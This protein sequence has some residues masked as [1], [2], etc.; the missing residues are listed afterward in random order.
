LTGST[1]SAPPAKC[2][3]KRIDTHLGGFK[4]EER[5]N[6]LIFYLDWTLICTG[7]SGGCSG[8]VEYEKPAHEPGGRLTQPHFKKGQQRF[9]VHCAGNCQNTPTS[10]EV[11]FVLLWDKRARANK[12]YVLRT[13]AECPALGVHL[14][15][16]FSL[17]FNSNGELDR[18][19][20][21]LGKT[22]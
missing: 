16:N 13:T 2:H 17:H 12:T 22:A 10:D 7:T 5:G 3:C 6:L 9:S 20:S 18:K 8:Y 11:K 14:E 19:R 1:G 15:T 4:F 21:H